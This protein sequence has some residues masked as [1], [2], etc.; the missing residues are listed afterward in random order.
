[1]VSNLTNAIEKAKAAGFMTV[2]LAGDADVD[3]TKAELGNDPVVL[4]VGSEGKGL[5][6]LVSETC[7]VRASIAI[8]DK[9]ESL[10]VSV[11]AAIA[12]HSV[13]TGRN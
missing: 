2:G 4:V 8:E 11:A 7:D 9:V 12:M 13:V 3:I 5:S 6:R 10:N 1:M